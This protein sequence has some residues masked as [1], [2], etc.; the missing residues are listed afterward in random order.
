MNRYIYNALRAVRRPVFSIN[1]L[2]LY[3]LQNNKSIAYI[4]GKAHPASRLL[5]SKATSHGLLLTSKSRTVYM[6][7]QLVI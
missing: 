1:D 7:R 4:R 2:S 5:K 6:C 3:R